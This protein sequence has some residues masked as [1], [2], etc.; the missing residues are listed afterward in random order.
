MYTTSCS[1]ISSNFVGDSID[2]IERSTRDRRPFFFWW[3]WGMARARVR[4]DM[5]VRGLIFLVVFGSLLVGCGGGSSKQVAP[6]AS[7]LAGNWLI[8][9]PMP[10]GS[11]TPPGTGVFSLAMSFDV[12]GNNITASA[13]GIGF[14]AS[15][16]SPPIYNDEFSFSGLTTGVIAA[17]GSF[18]LQTPQNIPSYS[19]S[20][21]G[22][23]PKMNAEQFSGTYAASFNSPTDAPGT[24]CIGN[25]AGM[26]TATSFPIVSGVYTG[27]GNFQSL[28][29]GVLT[30]TPVTI[31]TTLQQGAVVL[32][33]ATGISTASNVAVGGTIR[34]QGSPCFTSGVAN[35][36]V[37]HPDMEP[38]SSIQGNMIR[39]N[40][41]MNDG[42]TLGMSGVLTD[43]TEGH[44][45]ASFSVAP[46]GCGAG[47]LVFPFMDLTRQS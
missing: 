15:T 29:G 30:V 44:I 25:S 9:G 16:S 39:M 2:W 8:T 21:Q 13:Y 38:F 37:L 36:T 43:S 28:T 10:T 33:S 40:F 6:A 31:E 23:V 19:L 17:D 4:I 1:G 47:S 22:S 11:F 32:D 41:K 20:V 3:A 7:P 34:V 18:S 12:S 14:C 35:T 27:V 5:N 45:S 24:P 42:S 26:F 46:G